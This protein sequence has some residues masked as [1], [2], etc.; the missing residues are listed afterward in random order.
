VVAEVAVA[1]E[2]ALTQVVV[3]VVAVMVDQVM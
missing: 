2:T 1:V 3:L